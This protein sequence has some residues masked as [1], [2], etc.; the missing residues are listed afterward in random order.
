MS[1]VHADHVWPGDCAYGVA[2]AAILRLTR[3]MAV[4]LG[5]LGTIPGLGLGLWGAWWAMFADMVVRG[6]FFWA[7]F[8]RGGWKGQRV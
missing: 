8:A 7:R 6:I 2:K 3:S 4:E 5:P 1:S